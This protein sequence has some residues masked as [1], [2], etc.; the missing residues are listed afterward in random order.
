MGVVCCCLHHRQTAGLRFDLK[1]SSECRG[2]GHAVQRC[3]ENDV[4]ALPAVLVF[5]FGSRKEILGNA[6]W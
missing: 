1:E 3:L 5:C 4:C 6:Y 2:Q